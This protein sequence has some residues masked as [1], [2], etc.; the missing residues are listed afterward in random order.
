MNVIVRK[1]GNKTAS[2]Y[3]L[4]NNATEAMHHKNDRRLQFTVRQIWYKFLDGVRHE[5]DD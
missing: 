2:T 4:D 1:D 5:G 3:I